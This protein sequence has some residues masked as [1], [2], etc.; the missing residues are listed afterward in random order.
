MIERPACEKWDGRCCTLNL[1][2]GKPSAG[3]CRRCDAYVGSDRGLGDL[4]HRVA[5][6]RFGKV[7]VRATVGED[8]EGCRKRRA[9]WNGET[10]IE[11]GSDGGDQAKD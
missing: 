5:T 10:Q 7:I 6:S 8:C 11:G 2:G 3:V 4:V 1:F 9:E